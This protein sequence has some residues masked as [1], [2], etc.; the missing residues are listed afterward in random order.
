[1]GSGLGEVKLESI[2]GRFKNVPGPIPTNGALLKSKS[3]SSPLPVPER[4]EA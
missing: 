4:I 1:M 2:F 3:M